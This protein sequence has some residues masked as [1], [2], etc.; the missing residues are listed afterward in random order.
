MYRTIIVPL[1]G[2][3]LAEMVLPHV[4]EIAWRFEGRVILIRVVPP[5][6][7]MTDEA[8]LSSRR[9]MLD[10]ADRYLQGIQGELRAKG[11]DTHREILEGKVAE[12]I[13]DYAR[14]HQADL[15]A[16]TTHGRSGLS[17]LVYGSVADR[18]L[19][20]APCP[21]LLIRARQGE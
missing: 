1:D 20:T 8:T 11:I 17:R 21:V 5:S 3:P 18:V 12:A 13:V 16:M 9:A 7:G 14:R 10:E 6:D 4:E 2:S 15:L 19:R